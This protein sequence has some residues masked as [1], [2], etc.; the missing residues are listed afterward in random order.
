MA[1]EVIKKRGRS[2]YR[3]RVEYVRDEN[4]RGHTRW[5]YLG[6]VR[7]AAELKPLPS[8]STPKADR[9]NITLGRLIDA[10]ERLLTRDDYAHVTA[11]AI[12]QEAGVA[13]GTFYRHFKD[14]RDAL[15][16]AMQR[17]I[18][19]SEG[20]AT[21]HAPT[22]SLE[23]ER[24]RLRVWLERKLLLVSEYTGLWLAWS[25]LAQSDPEIALIRQALQAQY[26]H[27]LTVYLE[28]LQALGHTT[29]TAPEMASQII[30]ALIY[31]VLHN[32][33]SYSKGQPPPEIV[34]YACMMVDRMI[35]ANNGIRNAAII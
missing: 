8:T 32:G 35:F 24:Q 22:T 12:A 5:Q 3:Y 23:Q 19:R 2:A 34:E 31:G 10:L 27:M 15:R 16:A 6:A 1:Y 21:L 30:Y 28:Q 9:A 18:D 14:K 29:L 7:D 4:G 26:R 33:H 13:H 20:I 25:D 11:S 17:I